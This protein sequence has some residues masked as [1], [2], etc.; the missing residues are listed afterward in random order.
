LLYLATQEGGA[1]TRQLAGAFLGRI[2]PGG[3]APLPLAAIR[4]LAARQ[5]AGAAKALLA[6][7]PSSESEAI[8]T[9]V[10]EALTQLTFVNER[11][12]PD[13]VAAL[14]DALPAR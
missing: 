10:Q 9:A 13:V 2:I 4:L 8:A 5:P 11:A 1:Q 14:S 12:D 7:L 3:Y 6:Y